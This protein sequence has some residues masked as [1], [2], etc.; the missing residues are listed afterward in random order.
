MLI[1]I[2]TKKNKKTFVNDKRYTIVSVPILCEGIIEKDV[3]DGTF[4]VSFSVK[5]MTGRQIPGTVLNRI[6][7]SSRIKRQ[8]NKKIISRISKDPD[9]T[10]FNFQLAI[11]F[12]IVGINTVKDGDKVAFV[13]SSGTNYI[14]VVEGD[15]YVMSGDV[16]LPLS[17]VL[18]IE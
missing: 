18:I 1:D 12:D 3:R 9:I 10:E 8:V 13:N 7:N 6:E 11:I 14:G 2:I 5:L 16:K 17:N 4:D 15:K